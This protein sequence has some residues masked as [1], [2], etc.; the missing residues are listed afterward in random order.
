[1]R[2]KEVALKEK[3]VV[4]KAINATISIDIV[5][6]IS[7]LMAGLHHGYESGPWKMAFF[8]GPTSWSNFKKYQ[9]TKPLGPSQC[10]NQMWTKKN[11]HASKCDCADFFHICPKRAV[12]KK[13][14][15]LSKLLSSLGLYHKDI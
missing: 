7:R 11:D 10:E 1:M 12:L 2:A 9:F 14:S 15:G 5:L 6:Y 8:H 4:A 13:N 3:D